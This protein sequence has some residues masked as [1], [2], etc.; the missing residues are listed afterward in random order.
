MNVQLSL[1]ISVVGRLVADYV[2]CTVSS[3]VPAVIS[4][5]IINVYMCRRQALLS[6]QFYSMPG[7]EAFS[8]GTHHMP[9]VQLAYS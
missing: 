9:D 5:A 8:H 6:S 3:R 4:H 1:I 7:F 2:M